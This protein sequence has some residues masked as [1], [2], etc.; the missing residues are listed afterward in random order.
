MVAANLVTPKYGGVKNKLFTFGEKGASQ[1]L[2]TWLS[3]RGR[4]P[5]PRP[6]P[7]GRGGR[8]VRVSTAQRLQWHGRRRSVSHSL[9]GRGPGWG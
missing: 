1:F 8:A 9:G 5:L 2:A 6:S 7:A 4:S 3:G